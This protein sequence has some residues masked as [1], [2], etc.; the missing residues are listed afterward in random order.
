MN[1]SK[2]DPAHITLINRY[3]L[4]D[5]PGVEQLE[6]EERAFRDP[7]YMRLIEEVEVDLIDEY[8]RGGLSIRERRQ[9]EARFFGSAERRRKIE[10]AR[11]LAAIQTEGKED[12]E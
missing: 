4:G 12:P 2:E 10:F 1:R 3:L 9:F 7:E 11:S 5:L 8:V 6:I